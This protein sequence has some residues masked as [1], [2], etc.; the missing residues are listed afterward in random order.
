MGVSR[1]SLKNPNVNVTADEYGPVLV[2]IWWD[3]KYEDIIM[4]NN[5]GNTALILAPFLDGMK[6]A[7]AEFEILYTRKLNIKPCT[8]EYHCWFKTPGACY[9]KDDMAMIYPKF[10]EADIWVFAT[11]VYVDGVTGPMKNLMDRM[12]PIIKPF[13]ML[14]DGHCGHTLREG[15]R[16]SKVVLVSNCGLWGTYNFDPLVAQ[17]CG[18][19]LGNRNHFAKWPVT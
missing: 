17:H 2:I 12:V 15:Y 6:E 4:K 9:Q 3:K 13:I 16:D 1:E 10:Q 14:R 8:G 5:E 11:P 19:G 18:N 7:G